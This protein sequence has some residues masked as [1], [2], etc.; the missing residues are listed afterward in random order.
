MNI[1]SNLEKNIQYLSEALPLKNSFDLMTRTL[2]FG[3]TRAFWLGV[4]GLCQN[5][6]LQRIFSDLQDTGYCKDNS[7]KDIEHYMNSKI[8]YVQTSLCED[9]DAIIKNVL[10][11]PSA[12]F[13]DGFDKCILMDTRTYPNRSIGE[14]DTEK[15]TR[16][17][18]DGF[19]ES[20]VS[21]TALIRRRIR[22]PK[23]TFELTNLGT[24]SRTD[25]AIG[26]IEGK[27]APDIIEEIRRR[28]K[29]MD[30]TTVTMGSKSLEELLVK[31]R[32]FNPMP[33]IFST[34]RPDVACSYL[35]EGYV[36]VIVDTSP[37]ILI[38]PCTFFQ[39]TQAPEDYYKNFL[40]GNYIRMI[41]FFCIL[42]AL[43]AL[44]V[45]MLV[46]HEISF[47]RLFVYVILTELALD[48]FKYS[49]SHA[50]SGFSGS[51]S[52]VGGLILS[53]S[54]IRLNWTSTEVIFYGAATMLATLSLA[55][56]EFAEAIR[57]YRLFLVLCTGFFGIPGFV[58]GILLV[59]LSMATTPSFA[60]RSYFWPLFPPN[61]AALKK[62]LF[63]Y[64]TALAQPIKSNR[65]KR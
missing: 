9:W 13:L 58:G 21:N 28:L 19:I 47:V 61:A 54:A 15:V 59:V 50:P 43:L 20:L 12:L 14:P 39:F 53:D 37:S 10:S 63:R 16:G 24:E 8:G 57:L 35:S 64:P 30:V 5:D 26:Y 18:G 32:W 2:Y 52:I 1:S 31:K 23:L 3:D 17:A 6:L 45:F 7:V 65:K 42:I 29:K 40:V 36:A 60:D 44:P 51:L 4:N 11:G 22:H 25:I 62:V 33:C 38:L 27:A 34:E 48:L 46:Y 49:S 55:H 56:I 41:R